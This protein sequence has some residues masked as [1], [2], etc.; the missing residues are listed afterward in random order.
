MNE[1]ILSLRLSLTGREFTGVAYSGTTLSYGDSTIGIDISSIQ[2]LDKQ[3]PILL[4]HDPQT[5]IGF[6]KLR[7]QDGKLFIDGTLLDTKSAT[8]EIIT[9]AETGKE[10]QLSV[11]VESDRIS[12]R[13]SGDMLNGQTIEC[14]SVSVFENALQHRISVNAI[15]CTAK[16]LVQLGNL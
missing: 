5:P 4:E 1:I 13:K 16:L 8:Q 6:G 3:V 9:D 14:D 10:W 12:E 15:F 11:F 7:T 2:K